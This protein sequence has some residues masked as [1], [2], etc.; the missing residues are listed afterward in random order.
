MTPAHRQK[1]TADYAQIQNLLISL[2]QVNTSHNLLK[3]IKPDIKL[4]KP[5]ILLEFFQFSVHIHESK[6]VG[7]ENSSKSLHVSLVSN[8]KI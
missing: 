7:M 5:T 4:H 3:T 1:V 2:N 8:T 6:Q